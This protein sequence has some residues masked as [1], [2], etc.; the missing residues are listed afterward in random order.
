MIDLKGLVQERKKTW[1][2]QVLTTLLAR[3]KQRIHN[4]GKDREGN[5]IA[6]Q[7]SSDWAKVRRD[8]GRQIG[9]VDLEFM[10]DL[11]RDFQLGVNNDEFVLGVTQD[12]SALKIVANETRYQKEIYVPTDGEADNLAEIYADNIIGLFGEIFQG[13]GKNLEDGQST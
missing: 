3:M 7:Y 4:E 13:I 5:L 6:A 11:R 1:D 2:V 9:Y 12:L 8:N 10:G